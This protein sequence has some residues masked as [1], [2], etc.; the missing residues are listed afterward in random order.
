MA[1]DQTKE[2][3]NQKIIK[4]VIFVVSNI[5]GEQMIYQSIIQH[6]TQN[7]HKSTNLGMGRKGCVTISISLK[8]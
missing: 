5:I 3:D 8:C 6:M 2:I 4:I 1:L 7:P